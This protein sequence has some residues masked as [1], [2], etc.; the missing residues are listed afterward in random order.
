MAPKTSVDWRRVF[1][2]FER[3]QTTPAAERDAMVAAIRSE[4]PGLYPQLA[5]M[6]QAD[7]G[8]EQQGF[9]ADDALSQ[10]ATPVAMQRKWTDV[11]LGPWILREPIGIGGMGQVWLA[12]RGDNMYA[13][14]AAV[15]LM[16]L[17]NASAD[18]NARF[19]REGEFLARLAHPR[20]AQLYDAGLTEDGTRYLV[21][22]HVPGEALDEACDRRRLSIEAR[23]ELF[24]QVCEAVAYAHLQRVVHR[25]LKPSNILVTPDGHA[26]L[27]DFGIAKIMSDAGG[28]IEQTQLGTQC[29]TPEYAAPEQIEGY[30]ITTA[31]D[32][33]SLGVVLF[34]L[35]SG[36][37]PVD[38][39]RTVT[40]A[41]RKLEQ[42]R[43]TLLNAFEQTDRATIAEQRSTT[44][45]KL[46]HELRG[47]LANIVAKC[48]KDVPSERYDTAQAL[49]DDLRRYLVRE[50]L[51]AK[52][53]SWSYRA[54]KFIQR[55]RIQT[56]AAA[57]ASVALLIGIS[58]TTWQWRNAV[59][60]TKRTRTVVGVL[61][62]VFTKL[63]PEERASGQVSVVELLSRGWQQAARDVGNDPQLKAE[64]ARPLGLMLTSMGD[65]A[66]ASEALSVSRQ[67][68]LATGQT[69]S[70]EYQE[71]ALSLGFAQMRVGQV[72]KAQERFEE[73]IA[74]AAAMNDRTSDCSIYARI[75]L[76]IIAKQQGQ[77]QRAQDQFARAASDAKS[78]FNDKHPAYVI[79]R[80]QIV[81]V[82]R[83]LGRFETEEPEPHDGADTVNPEAL[84]RDRLE[85]AVYAVEHGQYAAAAAQL[86]E[87]TAAF[88]QLY[89]PQQT[90][91]IFS[92]VWL[93]VAL[94]H[95]GHLAASDTAIREAFER[96]N[97][98]PEKAVRHVVAI[99]MARQLLRSDRA[100]EAAPLIRQAL[101]Y[102]ASVDSKRDAE[103]ARVLQGELVLRRDRIAEAV[104][105]LTR[106]RDSQLRIFGGYHRDVCPT[107]LLRAVAVD[108]Q[109]GAS[110]A[111][112]LYQKARD[113]IF[114]FQP[115]GHP[116]RLK[117]QLFL[118]YASWRGKQSVASRAAL[119][120]ALKT[121]Q[122]AL[123]TRADLTAFNVLSNDLTRNAPLA[124]IHNNLLALL[125][126]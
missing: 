109:S 113:V 85:A 71:V 108:L 96:A 69:L 115:E 112:P 49:G 111:V 74:V 6:I 86:K 34:R 25:D 5:A 42:P 79:A 18:A 97:R 11:R 61:T 7:A 65:V 77:L 67:H 40:D 38:G 56:A 51:R 62:N 53:D 81:M 125:N 119:L 46:R 107:L 66:V 8:A 9:M 84:Q 35:L 2:V 122:Q 76:G 64:I 32:V 54:R 20:I 114:E 57:L 68:L 36:A 87:V 99:V 95:S 73:V 123:A 28:A 63:T 1:E 44:V 16:H 23:L 102:F 48:L 37:R 118:D 4:S 78:R 14:R 105:I 22:E 124:E 116:E 27:L 55:N 94:F 101:A 126:Y 21:L 89:S 110:A 82:A 33:Y 12:T 10:I 15:K 60:E 106:T 75:Q 52:P 17:A 26:K 24:L 83:E 43:R 90:E 70:V 121:Y 59:Q 92:Y 80:Q 31:T 58:A 104:D 98:S 39:I 100:A 3:W 117:A 103:R 30:A 93:S 13:G 19:A 50:P 41:V 72:R 45:S 29:Y 120:N 88:K 47:E 91:T